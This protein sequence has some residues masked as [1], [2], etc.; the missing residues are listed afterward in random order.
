MKSEDISF[1]L[2]LIGKPWVSGTSGPD[3]FD[4]WGLLRYILRER[5]GYELCAYSGVKETGILEMMKTAQSEAAYRWRKLTSPE[6]FCGVAMSHGRR[7]E[8]V[9]LWID[10][11]EAGG[12][13]HSQ[14]KSGVVYQTQQSI[15]QSGMRNFI[16]YRFRP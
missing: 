3:E 12:I 6:H 10:D 9:G 5:R 4:C 7:I 16:F 11:G 2:D 13:L 1:C 14:E 15:R 8:H